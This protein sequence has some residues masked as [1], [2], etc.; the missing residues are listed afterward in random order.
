MDPHIDNQPEHQLH[1]VCMR[2]KKYKK[3]FQKIKPVLIVSSIVLAFLVGISWQKVT[4]FTKGVTSKITISKNSQNKSQ[5]PLELGEVKPVGE[6]DHIRGKKNARIV[7]IEYSDFESPFSKEFHSTMKQ[8]IK[9]YPN[10]IMWVYRHFPVDELHTKSD[11]QAEAV[12]CARKIGGNDS[13]WALADKIFEVTP[14][15]NGLDNDTLPNLAT[16][17][18]IDKSTF[19]DC[20]NSGEF[21]QYVEDDYKS[22]I[23]AGVTGAPINILL[24]TKTNEELLLPGAVPLNQLKEI[25]QEMLAKD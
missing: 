14:S 25:I 15:N 20:L 9:E 16:S 19:Q 24:D 8:M 2:L 4:V 5:L 12:E 22:G 18:G 6:N 13:F 10:D 3:T 23:E 7:L 17:V 11:K 1:F 21:T